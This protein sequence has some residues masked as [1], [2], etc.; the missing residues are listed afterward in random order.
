LSGDAPLPDVETMVA[1]EYASHSPYGYDDYE[2]GEQVD[3]EGFYGE[4][5]GD[6]GGGLIGYFFDH[7]FVTDVVARL[8]YFTPGYEQGWRWQVYDCLD[9]MDHEQDFVESLRA[10]VT[11]IYDPAGSL[12]GFMLGGP[13]RPPVYVLLAVLNQGPVPRARLA[14]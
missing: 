5:N 2:K 6:F 1:L 11:G 12:S 3:R 9:R 10:G 8:N 4:E 13:E 14:S 7:N